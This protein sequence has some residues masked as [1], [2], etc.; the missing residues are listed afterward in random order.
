MPRAAEKRLIA[1]PLDNVTDVASVVRVVGTIEGVC[2]VL[3][4]KDVA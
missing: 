2:S 3:D 4:A 1:M